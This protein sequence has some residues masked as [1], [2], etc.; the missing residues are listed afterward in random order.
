MK[1]KLAQLRALSQNAAGK[2]AGIG[3]LMV[4]GISAAHAELPAEASDAISQV[5]SDGAAMIA[6]A[7]GP[8]VSI[9]GGLVLIKLFKKVV[10][11]AT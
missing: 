3:A 10:S 6:Q 4:A 7:W 2:T 9:V 5:G 11:R 1:N 8:V